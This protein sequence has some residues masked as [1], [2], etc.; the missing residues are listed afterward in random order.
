MVTKKQVF[1]SVHAYLRISS[2]GQQDGIGLDRQRE[3]VLKRLVDLG[4]DKSEVTWL[5]DPGLSAYAGLHIKSG[6]LGQF[7][8]DV[9]AGKHRGGLFICETVSRA[10][11]Q[12]GFAL[13][14]MLND[15][16]AADFSILFLDRAQP[17]KRDSM[18]RFLSVELT[19]LAELAQ[20]ESRLKSHYAKENWS[21]R[22]AAARETGKAFTGECPNWLEVVEGRYVVLED[23]AAAIREIYSLAQ[24]GYGISK[25]VRHA[26]TKPLTA[27]G[28]VGSWHMS[29]IKRVLTNR[30]VIGEFQ[31]HID[32]ERGRVPTGEPIRNYYPRVIEEDQFYAVQAIRA[33]A[34]KFPSR[35]DDNN[36]NY[37]MGI[38]KCACGG[39][40]RR[41]N[42]NSGAQEGYALYGCSN[43]VRGTTD[44]P[45]INARLFDHQF[46]ELALTHIPDMLAAGENQDSERRLSL[47][48]QL[49]SIATKKQ[50][51][52]ATIEDA[53]DLRAEF[54]D[55]LRELLAEQKRLSGELEAVLLEEA[56]PP[57]FSFDEAL[58]VFLPAYLDVYSPGTP[59]FDDAFRARALF[60]TRIVEAVSS[61]LV[62]TNRTRVTVKLKNGS[63]AA[64][65]IDKDES[66]YGQPEELDAM[67]RLLLDETRSAQLRRGRRVNNATP[68]ATDD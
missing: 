9:R 50:N 20:E 43:R 65:N 31:P 26:N 45:N 58:E 49:S 66:S 38:A 10:S 42:K 47:E 22:R 68:S 55:R 39:S 5:V 7:L 2:E 3:A 14:T 18:P 24:A 4:V 25:L 62:D 37:A 8:K 51:I 46:V 23:R 60:R 11:R 54:S 13:L 57:G 33:K 29:L 34:S 30:A 16:L 36:F 52:L 12:G 61:I 17:F 59:E 28:K 67:D 41:L 48:A 64:F 40:W 21:R 63:A 44:C 1:P 53:P 56:P 32:E 6:V 19:L 35:R 27:P 15:L